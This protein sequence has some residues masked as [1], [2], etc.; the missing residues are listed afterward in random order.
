MRVGLAAF[1]DHVASEPALARTCIVES[2]S[3]GP[4]AVAQYEGSIR[5][6]VPLF[7]MGRAVSPQ[8]GQLPA[9]LEET[10]VGGIFWIVYQ[11]IVGGRADGIGELLPE[12]VEFSLTP[13]V[14]AAG[15]RRAAGIS[16]LSA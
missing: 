2:L 10:I 5:A 13:Y 16:A 9:T 12:L 15:A 7:R 14:G 1:L 3:A 11:R 8:G 6:F 4:A